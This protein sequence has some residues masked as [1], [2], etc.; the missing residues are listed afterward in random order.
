MTSI[1]F[2]LT[3]GCAIFLLVTANLQIQSVSSTIKQPFVS[4]HADLTTDVYN[5]YGE[6]SFM[7]SQSDPVLLKY[8]DSIEDFFYQTAPMNLYINSETVGYH[9]ENI[10]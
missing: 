4:D 8:K 1:I 3:L 2:S 5:I 6:P 7:A 10:R 9:F